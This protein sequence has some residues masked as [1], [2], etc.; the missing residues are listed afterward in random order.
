MCINGDAK[1]KK[2]QLNIV[3]EFL[4]D[5]MG[6][7]FHSIEHILFTIDSYGISMEKVERYKREYFIFFIRENKFKITVKEINGRCKIKRIENIE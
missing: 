2:Q 3:L 7:R 6:I 1:V 5:F 4:R